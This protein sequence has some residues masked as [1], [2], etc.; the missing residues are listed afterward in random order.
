MASQ[1]FISNLDNQGDITLSSLVR[2]DPFLNSSEILCISLLSAS[3]MNIQQNNEEAMLF[4]RSIMTIFD[5][6]ENITLPLLVR[7]DPFSNSFQILFMP[8][9]SACFMKI[10]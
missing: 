10:L 5:N 1:V 8:L 7:S 9:L 6:Q 2:S 4:T 3:F